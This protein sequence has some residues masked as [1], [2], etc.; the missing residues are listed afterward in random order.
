ML[1]NYID[2]ASHSI[3]NSAELN[4]KDIYSLLYSLLPSLPTS[5]QTNY[6]QWI[7]IYLTLKYNLDTLEKEKYIIYIQNL[8]TIIQAHQTIDLKPYYSQF[9][10]EIFLILLLSAIIAIKLGALVKSSSARGSNKALLYR[11][12]IIIRVYNI[13]D[14]NQTTTLATIDL[15]H[16]KNSGGK[17]RQL[18]TLLIK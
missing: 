17:G 3:N 11:N 1:C 6:K 2:I 18:V 12:I 14:L 16:I 8:Y 15:I 13:R 10:I 9:Q 5:A 7:L 4:I